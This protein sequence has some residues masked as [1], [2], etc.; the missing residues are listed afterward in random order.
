MKLLK[1]LI[2]GL[3]VIGILVLGTIIDYKIWRAEHPNAQTWTYF[4]SRH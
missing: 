3:A 1:S 4:L 2:I